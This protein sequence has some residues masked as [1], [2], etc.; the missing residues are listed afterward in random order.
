MKFTRYAI[1]YT[2]SPG[3][4]SAFAAAWLGW[5]SVNGCS[6]APPE[7]AD[8][9]A[10]ISDITITPR[11]Y[12]F[13]GT[14][15]P[16]FRLAA[17]LSEDALLSQ[18]ADFCATYAPIELKGMELAQL[19]RFLALVPCGDE[20]RIN[21]LAARAVTVFDAFR[22]PLDDAEIERRR[23]ANLSPVQDELL[24]KWGYPYVMQEFR[25]HMTLT[26]KLPK[27]QATKTRE[28]LEPHLVPLLPS[29]FVIDSLSL[30]GEAE[31]GG[32]FHVIDRIPL[33]GTA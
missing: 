5:D 32:M 30:M 7:I 29:P 3:P 21:Q 31:E 19:G 15:R 12:G 18:F 17:G 13:H 6:V 11:K 8:L 2:P 27:A 23:R 28:A 26:G 9:P 24:L 14:V 22:A 25:F 16:P 1:F 10:P 4:L 33:T 20:S